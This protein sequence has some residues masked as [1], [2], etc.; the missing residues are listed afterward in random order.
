[1]FCVPHD[2]PKVYPIQTQL[3]GLSQLLSHT[4]GVADV[5]NP[6]GHPFGR[7]VGLNGLNHINVRL[8]ES[9]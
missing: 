3:A 5:E 6:W 2:I 8:Q 1:M 4:K 9:S 7:M